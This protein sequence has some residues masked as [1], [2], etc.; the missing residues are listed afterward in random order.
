MQPLLGSTPFVPSLIVTSF[1]EPSVAD[2]GPWAR[3]SYDCDKGNQRAF[4]RPSA[5]HGSLA[6]TDS[7]GV[8]LV[9]IKCMNSRAGRGRTFT[10]H[11][12]PTSAYYCVQRSNFKPRSWKRILNLPIAELPTPQIARRKLLLLVPS[13]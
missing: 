12:I 3:F 2:I 8:S 13:R 7:L 9:F 4:V 1:R 5:E 10:V 11:F 6:L